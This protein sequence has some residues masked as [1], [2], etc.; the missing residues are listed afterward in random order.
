MALEHEP[1]EVQETFAG[2]RVIGPEQNQSEWSARWGGAPDGYYLP[3]RER[4]QGPWITRW[5]GEWR[6]DLRLAGGMPK[7]RRQAV[8]EKVDHFNSL[9]QRRR[10]NDSE[11]TKLV[12]LAERNAQLLSAYDQE[13]AAFRSDMENLP[14]DARAALPD[15]LRIR[16]ENLRAQRRQ[17]RPIIGILASIFEKQAAIIESNIAL[18]TELGEPQYQRMD[19]QGRSS[20]AV[21]QW[22][23]Q[24]INNDQYLYQ[25]L[26]ELTDYDVLNQQSR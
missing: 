16:L 3:D 10:N 11:L 22:Y 21:S 25:R 12:P 14:P 23:E 15:D 18:F 17:H 24:L 26:L 8:A 7:S 5:N 4:A 6:L 1:Y 13:A 9:Q 19:P 2:V 20:Y